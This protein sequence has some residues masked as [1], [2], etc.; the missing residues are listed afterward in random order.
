LA[1]IAQDKS[2]KLGSTVDSVNTWLD[3]FKSVA[4]FDEGNSEKHTIA[5]SG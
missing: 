2:K 3:D 5:S 1:K 4:N